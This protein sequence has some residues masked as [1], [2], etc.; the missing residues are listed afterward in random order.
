MITLLTNQSQWQATGCLSVL[1]YLDCAVCVNALSGHSYAH[2][3]RCGPSRLRPQQLREQHA[4]HRLLLLHAGVPLDQLIEGGGA[5]SRVCL[6]QGLLHCGAGHT[7]GRKKL[8]RHMPANTPAAPSIYA[9]QVDGRQDS[10]TTRKQSPS[11]GCASQRNSHPCPSHTLSLVHRPHRPHHQQG[12][13]GQEQHS[14]DRS[15]SNNV[16]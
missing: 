5:P 9:K 6:A 11:K 16:Q 2:G 10:L 7:G 13:R 8:A 14:M 3:F 15:G 12:R 4:P 1:E